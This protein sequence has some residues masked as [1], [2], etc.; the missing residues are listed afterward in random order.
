MKKNFGRIVL[1]GIL[2]LALLV[3]T[4]CGKSNDAGEQGS[5][6]GKLSGTITVAGSTSV[7]PFSEVLAEEFQAVNTG[8]TVN[9][10]GGGSSQGVEAV[11]SGAA[12]IGAASRDLKDEEKARANLL[13]TP[14]A[15]DGVAVVVNPAN[16]VSA[17]TAEDIKNIYIGNIKNWQELGGEDAPI[18]II[19]REEGSGTRDA[20]SEIVLNKEDIVKDAIIQNSTGAVKTGVAG[21]KNAIGYIS[22]AKV[23]QAVKALRVDG[24]EANEANVKNGSY[25]VQRPFI[26]ITNGEPQGLSKAFI[27]YVLSDEGQSIISE[28]GA[29]SIQ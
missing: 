15:L 1:T 26:Y 7:Q 25:K 28:E 23:D 27:E 4:G 9:V 11:I 12:Q 24:V 14:I 5:D 29:F 16:K 13:V 17:L 6:S 22:M 19:S 8:V 2:V 20:F 18:T 3:V 21:D 10:Q